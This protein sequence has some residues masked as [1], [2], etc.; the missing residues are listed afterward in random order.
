MTNKIGSHFDGVVDVHYHGAGGHSPEHAAHAARA[1]RYDNVRTLIQNLKLSPSEPVFTT[2]GSNELFKT[3]YLQCFDGNPNV[4]GSEARHYNCRACLSFLETYGTLVTVDDD[5]KRRSVVFTDEVVSVF[6]EFQNLKAYVEARRVSGVFVTDVKV[7]GTPVSRPTLKGVWTHLAIRNPGVRFVART[8]S[9]H[10]YAAQKLEGLGQVVRFIHSPAG[11]QIPRALDLVRT[12]MLARADKVLPNLEWLNAQYEMHTLRL[13]GDAKRRD[14]LLWRAVAK[15][16]EGF[17][18][19]ASGMVG[20]LCDQLAQGVKLDVIKASWAEKMDPSAYQRPTAAPAEQNIDKA[21]KLLSQLGLGSWSLERA[22]A[23]GFDLDPGTMWRPSLTAH[24]QDKGILSSG[25]LFSDLRAEV[26][27]HAREPIL[28][29]SPPK[30]MTWRTFE[31]DHL[32]H[33][34]KLE[35]RLDTRTRHAIRQFTSQTDTIWVTGDFNSIFRWR[36]PVASYVYRQGSY[37][38]EFLGGHGIVS[39][40]SYFEIERIVKHPHLWLPS[41]RDE[42]FGCTLILKGAHDRQSPGLALF[43]EVLRAELHPV[44]DVF[45]LLSNKRKLTIRSNSS[46][47]GLDVHQGAPPVRL[48]VTTDSF[49]YEVIVDRIE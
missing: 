2:E 37:V 47:A 19:P 14:A 22:T 10:Q 33:A 45:E 23:T 49:V 34:R 25:G 16:P 21:E 4:P 17:L 11:A 9:A 15:A 8:Q 1:I 18:H 46:G 6:P 7:W 44:R 26:R 24:E 42:L 30:M 20:V 40:M 27:Q 5:G 32:P 43:P 28:D 41:N 38:G 48:R 12:G 35:A 39:G 13:I 36:H 29:R 3:L 31:R